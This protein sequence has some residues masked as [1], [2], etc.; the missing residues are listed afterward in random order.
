M[1]DVIQIRSFST[2][3]ADLRLR[4][5]LFNMKSEDPDSA[6]HESNATLQPLANS[7]L[8]SAPLRVSTPPL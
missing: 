8:S 3:F 2:D 5:R 7:N 1:N 6:P 4:I